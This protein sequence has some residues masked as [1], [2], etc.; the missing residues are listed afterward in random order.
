MYSIPPKYHLHSKFK[1]NQ[2]SLWKI[3]IWWRKYL[4]MPSY[5]WYYF[6]FLVVS[7]HARCSS[8]SAALAC[9]CCGGV[10]RMDEWRRICSMSAAHAQFISKPY[11]YR[12]AVVSDYFE[13][14]DGPIAE[15]KVSMARAWPQGQR[16]MWDFDLE[17]EAAASKDKRLKSKC[18]WRWCIH[19]QNISKG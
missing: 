1:K 9:L 2:T 17:A 12:I 5:L 6:A 14:T 3:C 4:N 16:R 18:S 7:S 19:N 8:C 13:P 11:L 10:G 15:V